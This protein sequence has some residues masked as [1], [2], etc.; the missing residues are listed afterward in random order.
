MLEKRRIKLDGVEYL[1]I[2]NFQDGGPIVYPD[3]FDE[4]S[5]KEPDDSV[6]FAY[7]YRNGVIKRYGQRI[8]KIR[9]LEFI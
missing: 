5:K 8:G 6:V 4:F 9:D 2:G 7:L 3:K 1:L